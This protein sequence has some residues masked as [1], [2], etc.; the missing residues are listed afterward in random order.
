MTACATGGIGGNTNNNADDRKVS[1]SCEQ[2]GDITLKVGFSEASDTIGE[3]FRDLIAKFEEANPTVKIDLQAKEW[4]SS[5]QTIRLV[6]SGDEPPDVM[7]GNEGWSINGALWEAGLIMDLDAYADFF[8]WFDE[9]PESAMMVNRFTDDFKTLGEGSLVAVPQAIQYAGVFYNKKVLADLGVTDPAVLDDKAKFMETIEAAKNA[10]MDPVVLGDAEKWTVLHNLSLFNGW[11]DTPETINAW[12]FNT[13]GTTYDTPGRLKG[14]TD[15]A[16]WWKKG[17]F[18]SDAMA[19]TLA[20]ATARFVEGNSPFFITGTWSLGAV[21]N[22]LGDDAGFMLWPAA[23]DGQH[24][25]V[26]GYN[27]PFTISTKTKYPDC[28]ARFIDYVTT[29]QDAIDAQIAAG[30]PSATIEGANAQ[31]DDPLLAQMISEY[32]RLNADDGLFTWEDWPT[33][34]MGNLMGTECQRMMLGEITPQ[35]YNSMVQADWEEYMANR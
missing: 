10:G 6:M 35:Q 33:P 13:P 5:Q 19:M 1:D 27:L 16:D 11:Y 18:N 25:A 9:F 15:L 32:Q 29:S 12:V 3:G 8:G 28:A 4:A 2:Y 23:E 21:R 22:G 26:G 31:V 30:R 24:R 34:S 14:S 17:Y 7:Q 20:D